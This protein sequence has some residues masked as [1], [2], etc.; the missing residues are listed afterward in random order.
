[1]TELRRIG[2]DFAQGYLVH[3][4]EPLEVA[5]NLLDAQTA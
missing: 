1:V 3:R 2:V 5:L 4:P